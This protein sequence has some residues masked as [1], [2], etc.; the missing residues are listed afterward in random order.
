[1]KTVFSGPQESHQ[2]SL[3]ILSA[4]QEYD[5]F[6][7]SIRTV[8]DL[9]CGSGL[10]LEW[11]ATRT[12]REENPQPL[13]INCV[14]VDQQ[15]RLPVAHN[16][17]N[18]TY[19]RTNFEKIIHPP[20]DQLFD[21]L[22]CHDSFQYCITPIDTLR[23][24]RN[25][26]SDGC[27]LAVSVPQTTNLVHN[28]LWVQQTSGVYYH[29]SLVSLI[30]MLC[31]SGWDCHTGYFSKQPNAPWITAIVYKSQYEPMDPATTTWYDLA[32]K[33]LLPDSAIKS[34]NAHGYLRQEDLLIEWLDHSLTWMG[35][36]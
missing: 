27:M 5:E 14:G 18:I 26:G 9:G 19:Q 8:V 2:H 6:M 36:Q 25:I 28:Q 17:S 34:I 21:V 22:W 29:Y 1:M 24:W 12:T 23:L 33:K 15:E 16:Y 35:K 3:S 11:W 13:N 32:D 4:L 30:H 7:E 10:D 20:K 31:V